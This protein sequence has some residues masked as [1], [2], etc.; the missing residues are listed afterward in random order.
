MTKLEMLIERVRM[1][2]AEQQEAFADEMLA[3]LDMPEPPDDFG[4][5]GS[6]EELAG[7]VR[8]WRENPVAIPAADLHA[9]LK[10]LREKA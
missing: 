6:D 9:L 3:W 2:P 10:L 8:A 4:P 7:R 1:L 5:D